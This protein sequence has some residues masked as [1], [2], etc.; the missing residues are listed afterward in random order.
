MHRDFWARIL[1]LTVAISV[2][3]CIGE[4]GGEAPAS[5]FM[6]VGRLGLPIN[7]A[8]IWGWRGPHGDFGA[9]RDQTEYFWGGWDLGRGDAGFKAVLQNIRNLPRHSVMVVNYPALGYSGSEGLEWEVCPFREE[10]AALRRVVLQG[11][12]TLVFIPYYKDEPIW[13]SNWYV[14]ELRPK[15]SEEFPLE[16]VLGLPSGD[17]RHFAFS[18]QSKLLFVSHG[19]GP[20]R[21]AQWDVA[22][23]RRVHGYRLGEESFVD[24]LH[25]TPDGELLVVC[26][27]DM[28][29][30]GE[31]RQLLIDTRRHQGIA[32][33]RLPTRSP[34]V[35]FSQDGEYVRIA[36]QKNKVVF[37]SQGERVTQWP[38]GAFGP[39][40]QPRLRVT[41]ASQQPTS[42]V[43]L[44]WYDEEGR[45]QFHIKVAVWRDNY[46]VSADRKYIAAAD[47]A[48][49]VAV[50]RV[51]DQEIVCCYKFASRHVLLA[52]D[53]AENRFLVVEAF[54]EASTVLYAINLPDGAE[55]TQF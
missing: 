46:G 48:G 50:W 24:A 12:H 38:D 49:H 18:G 41:H 19:S 35:V 54:T 26:L 45:E 30:A 14:R 39:E 17:V 47:G 4:V 52:Y 13:E 23:K 43:G 53:E 32:Q 20:D 51:E 2:Q 34:S 31:M 8:G 7:C 10:A 27:Y 22:S 16:E 40:R 15:A 25:S 11:D 3:G 42:P 29:V 28:L 55:G 37:D 6:Y 9:D 5:H 21:V 33:A 44:T 36:D 1:L